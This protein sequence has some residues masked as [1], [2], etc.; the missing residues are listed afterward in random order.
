[1]T[2]IFYFLL[3]YLNDSIGQTHKVAFSFVCFHFLFLIFDLLVFCLFLFFCQ[4]V[5]DRSCVRTEIMQLTHTRLPSHTC[6][7]ERNKF[8]YAWNTI[9][10][11]QLALLTCIAT[12]TKAPQENAVASVYISDTNTFVKE[13]L[14]VGL[15]KTFIAWRGNLNV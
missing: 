9:C 7:Q 12:C 2:M 6:T 15:P 4:R 13:K 1:M 3:F 14:K 8:Q 10:V 5:D 11:W